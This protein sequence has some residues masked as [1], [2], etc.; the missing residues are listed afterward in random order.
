MV[1]IE[2]HLSG[3]KSLATV[4]TG[5]CFQEGNRHVWNS[6]SKD[7][8]S[9]ERVKRKRLLNEGQIE[10]TS[11]SVVSSEQSIVL[12][13]CGLDILKSRRYGPLHVP[14][15]PSRRVWSYSNLSGQTAC[16]ASPT[17]WMSSPFL[18]SREKRVGIDLVHD[19]VEQELV[20]EAEIIRGVTAL[21][22]RTLEEVSEQIRCV[23]AAH[24]RPPGVCPGNR[25]QA[26]REH[27][28]S[29]LRDSCP[30]AVAGD[31]GWGQGFTPKDTEPFPASAQPSRSALFRAD[32]RSR[33]G[34]REGLEGQGG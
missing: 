32:I 17:C 7:D 9:N 10:G 2:G 19:K 27:A 6:K 22:T 4:R 25:P 20:K 30:L 11:V 31:G 18:S 16:P 14:A 13:P 8:V 15:T 29:G 33:P 12:L 23:L 5:S 21:L 28:E 1:T 26:A 24:L 34:G 3:F